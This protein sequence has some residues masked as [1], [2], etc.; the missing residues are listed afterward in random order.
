MMKDSYLGC[1]GRIELSCAKTVR[2]PLAYR[3]PDLAFSERF[4]YHGALSG[5]EDEKSLPSRIRITIR[6]G[7]TRGPIY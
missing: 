1:F 3:P 7:H 6:A 4:Q 2:A 5:M